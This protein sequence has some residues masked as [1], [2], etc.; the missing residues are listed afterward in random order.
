MC[1]TQSLRSDTSHTV[2]RPHL[3]SVP[4]LS[5][6]STVEIFYGGTSHT[7]SH[8]HSA[9]APPT[10]QSLHSGTSHTRQSRDF[11]RW[12]FTH[13]K[14]PSFCP[15]SQKEKK[16]A[17]PSNPDVCNTLLAIACH[18]WSRGVSLPVSEYHIAVSK[19]ILGFA[20]SACAA[21][22]AAIK[23]PSA[24][25]PAVS[26]GFPCQQPVAPEAP[27][28]LPATAADFRAAHSAP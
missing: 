10:N 12:H 3:A 6:T 15:S 8:L 21:P 19:G 28:A 7:A 1:R 26:H 9:W 23:L 13:R 16:Q 20:V 4:T 14:L 11:L 18:A 22:S 24:P 17:L 25:A 2:E 27:L 5:A